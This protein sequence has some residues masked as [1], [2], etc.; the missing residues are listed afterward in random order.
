MVVR[1]IRG[2]ITVNE[3]NPGE[4]LQATNELLKEIITHNELDSED[5]V[6]I[7]FTVTPDL[8][9]TFPAE[10]ARV[11]GLHLV[12][13]LCSLEIGVKGSIPRC[14]RVLLHINTNKTQAEIKHCFLRDASR[15]RE[16]LK[17]VND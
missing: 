15:L 17:R 7:I 11:M 5:I 16:D 1:G 4:I 9:S 8:N 14:I 2:A 13:L 10:A 3:D 6:S 12:P